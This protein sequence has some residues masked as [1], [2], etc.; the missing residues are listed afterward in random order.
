LKVLVLTRS[1]GEGHNHVALALGEAFR[2]HGH[3]CTVADAAMLLTPKRASSGISA[4]ASRVLSHGADMASRWYG[5]VAL[6][7]PYAFGL[8]ASIGKAYERTSLPSPIHHAN[9]PYVE[10]LRAYIDEH[11]VDV[12]LATHAFPQEAMADVRRRYPS[13]VR[14]YSVLTD[15]SCTPFFAES[16]TDGYFIPHEDVRADCERHKLPRELTYALGMPVAAAF[17]QP[18]DRDG[19]RAELGLPADVPMFLLMSGGVG[20]TRVTEICDRLL[21]L[22]GQQ[23]HV[24]VLSGRR[25]EMYLRVAERYRTDRRV[26]VVPFTDRVPAYMAATDILISKPGA[27]SSSEAAVFGVPLVHTGAIPGIEADNGRFFQD[28]GMSVFEPRIERAAQAAFELLHDPDR[29]AQMRADQAAH[30][31][32]DGADRVVAQVEALGR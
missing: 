14:Y 15:Y 10:P 26:T 6:K 9:L 2:A 30:L 21:T 1:T 8:V 28:R 31:I 11:G 27:A 17:R 20:S 25:E 5:W 3:D 29:L 24:V 19:A 22:A 7:Q 23:V 32:P 4:T 12:V 18:R 13:R 16:A